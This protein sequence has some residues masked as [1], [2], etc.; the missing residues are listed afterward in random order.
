MK[1]EKIEAWLRIYS[2][3]AIESTGITPVKLIAETDRAYEAMMK[4][5]AK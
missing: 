2:I 4:T 5:V 3:L 1:Q